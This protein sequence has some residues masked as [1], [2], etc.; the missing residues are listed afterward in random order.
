MSLSSIAR[1]ALARHSRFL[2]VASRSQSTTFR[3]TATMTP[4]IDYYKDYSKQSWSDE[5]GL[6]IDTNDKVAEKSSSI[7]QTPPLA[8]SSN[9]PTI[10]RAALAQRTSVFPVTSRS[11][12][13][14][15]RNI[16]LMTTQIDYY[17]DYSKQAWRREDALL[18]IMSEGKAEA[19]P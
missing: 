19:R 9:A 15:S 7:T 1:T 5:G 17:K 11:K 3:D 13:T 14:L 6:F 4:Q 10:A 16:A 18:K 12:S 8:H 2:S